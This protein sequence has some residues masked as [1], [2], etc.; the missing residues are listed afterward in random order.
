M[1][2]SRSGTGSIRSL[3]PQRT[4]GSTLGRHRAPP[5]DNISKTGSEKVDEAVKEKQDNEGDE[6][7]AAI[8]T[9]FSPHQ[10]HGWR[11]ETRENRAPALSRGG[12][13]RREERVGA[14][15]RSAARVPGRR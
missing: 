12:Q 3:A 4:S 14:S 1:R 13:G 15:R 8:T 7:G 2:E 9:I 11:G 5:G 6:K 10:G